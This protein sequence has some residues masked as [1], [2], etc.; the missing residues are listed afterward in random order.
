MEA[1]PN[2]TQLEAIED[3]QQEFDKHAEAFSKTVTKHLPKNPQ[4]K[5]KKEF[6]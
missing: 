5:T 4:I 1:R 6:Q 2:T 3:L